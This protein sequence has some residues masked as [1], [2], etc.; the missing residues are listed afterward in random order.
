MLL[1]KKQ[2]NAK[3][4]S[5]W[6]VTITSK[7]MNLDQSECRKI[8]NQLEI[9]TKTVNQH[10]KNVW[11]FF[12]NIAQKYK[13]TSAQQKSDGKFTVMTYSYINTA[14]SQWAFRIYKC[15]IINEYVSLTEWPSYMLY[16]RFRWFWLS[17][18]SQSIRHH[19]YYDNSDDISDNHKF[20]WQHNGMCWHMLCSICKFT[21]GYRLIGTWILSKHTL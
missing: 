9:Y 1:C 4:Y 7:T 3:S 11:H 5:H 14:L 8:N 19:C 21:L 2:Q 15:C 17:L 20:H 6:P 12:Y 16:I 13:I 18:V 10:G